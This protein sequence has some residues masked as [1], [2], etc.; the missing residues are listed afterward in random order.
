MTAQHF[1]PSKRSFHQF[2]LPIHQFLVPTDRFLLRIHQLKEGIY[3]A[4]Y[5]ESVEV[6]ALTHWRLLQWGGRDCALS[7]LSAYRAPVD[8]CF[9]EFTQMSP[10]DFVLG[11][12][13]FG[14]GGDDGLGGVA[15]EGEDL[16]VAG[17]VG[18]LEVDGDA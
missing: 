9:A 4:T 15:G 13:F 3:C 10:Q 17:E 6:V 12:A 14:V 8:V 18:Y 16:T 7:T 1:F 11:V 5:S 2:L